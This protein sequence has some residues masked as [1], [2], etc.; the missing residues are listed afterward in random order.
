MDEVLELANEAINDGLDEL[1]DFI[2]SGGTDTSF[3][4]D[5]LADTLADSGY[6]MDCAIK[7]VNLHV[8]GMD[9]GT[10]VSRMLMSQL[11]P[12]L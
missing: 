6:I 3:D 5:G 11:D 10:M 7:D 8:I 1:E 12:T 4:V 2:N 9:I